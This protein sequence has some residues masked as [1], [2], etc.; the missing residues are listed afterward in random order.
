MANKNYKKN[1][2][3]SKKKQI[4]K[5]AAKSRKIGLWIVGLLILI[6]VGLIIYGLLPSGH[7][8][9]SQGDF[10]TSNKA[11]VQCF[12]NP[13]FPQKYGMNPPYAIDL[14][15]NMENRGLRIIEANTGKILKLPGWENFGF[16]GL[17]TRD[18]FGNIYTSP[19][20]YVSIDINPPAEQNKI[21]R[22]DNT[23]GEMKEFVKLP[24]DNPPTPTNPFGVIGLNF[25]CETNSLYATSVAGSGIKKETGKIFQID[26]STGKIEDTYDDFDALGIALFVGNDGKRA[27][28]GSARKPEIYSVGIDE[29][30]G[31]K[32]DLRFEFSL[33]DVPNGSFHKAHR[34]KIEDDIMTLKTREFSYTLI[35]ASEVMRTN[36]KF[37]YN[38]NKGN[39]E[40]E[41][42]TEE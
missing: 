40:F 34:I 31:F 37:R 33:L 20:P 23:T 15:Q 32:N 16:L 25:D 10:Y 36:Y 26:P 19:V 42:L 1:K 17:Y 24:S 39:W 30:G 6:I 18:Q 8:K 38:R 35:A 12:K 13:D 27:Y 2:I 5:P 41:G 21:L 7:S 14:K 4:V 29:D 22:V 28:L 3:Q 11:L 9:L